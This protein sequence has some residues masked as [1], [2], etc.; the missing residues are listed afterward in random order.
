M[1]YILYFIFNLF[2]SI[3]FFLF[4]GFLISFYFFLFIRI[5][6]IMFVLRCLYRFEGNPLRQVSVILLACIG[7]FFASFS[8][9]V[10]NLF[11]FVVEFSKKFVGILIFISANWVLIH[12]YISLLTIKFVICLKLFILMKID[13]YFKVHLWEDFLNGMFFYL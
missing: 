2:F 5:I 11:G 9:M 6:F 1:F 7:I 12:I 10:R 3:C 4:M 13:W 8:T